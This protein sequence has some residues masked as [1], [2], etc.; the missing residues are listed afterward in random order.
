MIT[1]RYGAIEIAYTTSFQLLWNDQRSGADEDGAFWL[2]KAQGDFRPIGPIVVRNYDDINGRRG[3]L[4]V[5]G[6]SGAVASPTDYQLIWADKGSG[7]RRDGAVWRPVPP[8]GYV[9]LGDLFWNGYS[10]PPTN[11]IWCVRA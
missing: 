6:D 4:L 7:A 5:R 3:G 10:K 8:A 11:A 1:Q 2:P 9:A